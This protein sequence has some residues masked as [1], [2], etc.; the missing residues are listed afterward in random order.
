MGV[1]VL[2]FVALV[3][4]GMLLALQGSGRLSVLPAASHAAAVT[5][6]ALGGGAPL[7][8]RSGFLLREMLAF[9]L[10]ALP[11]LVL[12]A[13]V[14]GKPSARLDQLDLASFT[15]CLAVAA[16]V[17]YAWGEV[18]GLMGSPL[19]RSPQPL[20]V[21]AA[22]FVFGI[23]AGTRRPT[24][25]WRSLLVPALLISSGFGSFALARSI[26][27]GAWPT[28]ADLLVAA[29]ILPAILVTLAG[30]AYYPLRKSLGDRYGKTS[31]PDLGGL[32]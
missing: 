17:F 15:P 16:G 12:S 21:F 9:T 14:R 28:A 2:S 26:S 20:G 7:P 6:P 30:S 11:P 32:P 5:L 1:S 8:P 19:A 18:V 22:S 10:V 13:Q 4:P 31:K 25:P 29:P 27:G 3:L 24:W 23:L